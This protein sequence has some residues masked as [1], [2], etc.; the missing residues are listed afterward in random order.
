L[1]G[2][3]RRAGGVGA[4][5]LAVALG[6]F[7]FRRLRRKRGRTPPA[8][9]AREIRASRQI[10]LLFLLAMGAGIGLLVLYARGGQPQLEGLL[11][12]VA[13]GGMGFA[14]I[15]W[16]RFLFPEGVVTEERGPHPSALDERARTE[17]EMEGS[18]DEVTRRTFLVRL[19]VGAAGAFGVAM[20]FPVASLGPA[21][22]ESLL[23]T[24]WRRGSR[25]VDELGRPVRADSLDVGGVVTVFPEGRTDAEDS[26]A[27]LVKVPPDDL[28]L[29]DGR[30]S[31]APE[32]NVCYSKICTHAGCPVGLYIAERHELQCP[33]HQSAFDVLDGAEVL[34]GPAPRP[35]PQLEL[36]VDPLGYLRAANDFDQPVGP[37]FWNRP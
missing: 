6:W 28:G 3:L 29:P 17:D 5:A 20:L 12:G 4:G 25:V 34:F 10:A 16:G 23:H 11:L 1:T 26:Q 8:S 19:L 36:Y 30:A 21:P 15:L 31:W 27:I 18:A 37:A 9:T 2:R 32:G 24:A 7:G 22:A 33:C 35:L 13:L 14:L